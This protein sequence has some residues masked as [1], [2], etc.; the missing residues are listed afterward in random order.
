MARNTA[1][2]PGAADIEAQA[3][4]ARRA[5]AETLP[6]P[7][8]DAPARPYK[9]APADRAGEA[10]TCVATDRAARELNAADTVGVAAICAFALAAPDPLAETPGADASCADGRA[11][12]NPFAEIAGAA[13]VWTLARAAPDPLAARAG[14]AANCALAEIVT[15]A[16]SAGAAAA[17][18]LDLTAPAVLAEIAG[19]AANCAPTATELTWTTPHDGS[20]TT[21]DGDA[22]AGF[23]ERGAELLGSPMPVVVVPHHATGYSS[24]VM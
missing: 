18:A 17:C 12:A 4:A 6:A 14:A 1:D 11:D 3:Q 2:T 23:A 20:G 15:F 8:A 13:A 5:V 24:Q 16:D 22:A 21:R 9:R 7:A 10:A 19:D